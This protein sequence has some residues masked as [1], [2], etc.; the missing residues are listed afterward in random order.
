MI[1]SRALTVPKTAC[2]GV[3]LESFSARFT[4]SMAAFNK[5]RVPSRPFGGWDLV[6]MGEI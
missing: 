3:M 6:V 5:E 1:V 2:A 4:A